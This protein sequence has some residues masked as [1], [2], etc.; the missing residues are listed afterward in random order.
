M[1][2]KQV[3]FSVIGV[4]IAIIVIAAIVIITFAG[5]LD[6]SSKQVYTKT[7]KSENK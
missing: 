2:N 1:E 4:F 5:P 3:Q 6:T 7:E